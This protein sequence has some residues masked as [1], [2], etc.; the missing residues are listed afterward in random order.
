MKINQVELL[1][2][3]TKKNIRFYEEQGLL[4]PGRNRENGYRDY[5]EEDVRKLEQIKLFR[6]LGLPLEEIRM[7]QAGRSTVADSMKRHLV[8]LKR[9]QENVEHSMKLCEMLRETEGLLCDLDTRGLMVKMEE[10]EKGGAY[11]RDI[12]KK[13]VRQKRYIGAFIASAAMVTFMAGLI[14]LMVWDFKTHPQDALPLPVLLLIIA[15]PS[16]VIVGVVMSLA[17]RIGEIKKGEVDD[18]RKF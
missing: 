15:V 2:G 8:T 18:A 4:S 7:M 12:E 1:V 10:L 11:F 14:V 5:N 13:D 17:Q 16:A 9:E 3:I 6:K